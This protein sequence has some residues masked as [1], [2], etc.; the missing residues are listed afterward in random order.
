MIKLSFFIRFPNWTRNYTEQPGN[1][2]N[3]QFYYIYRNIYSNIFTITLKLIG[4]N[5][6]LEDLPVA[7][8]YKTD[9]SYSTKGETF[10]IHTLKTLGPIGLNVEYGIWIVRQCWKRFFFLTG[11][12]L[13]TKL[14]GSY[15]GLELQTKIWYD[16]IQ[17]QMQNPVASQM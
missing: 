2:H 1:M 16:T 11:H 6:F 17:T 4:H 3:Y 12:C 15:I 8:I 14:Y 5:G 7:L 13:D 9:G 10:R